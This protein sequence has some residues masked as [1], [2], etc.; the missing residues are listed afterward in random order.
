MKKN[1][2]KKEVFYEVWRISPIGQVTMGRFKSKEKAEEMKKNWN[3][4]NSSFDAAYVSEVEF[5]D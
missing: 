5:N 2:L 1:N 3:K 4:C